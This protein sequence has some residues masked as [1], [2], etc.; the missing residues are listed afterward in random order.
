[1]YS[2]VVRQ[3]GKYNFNIIILINSNNFNFNVHFAVT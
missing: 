2:I 1:M 3:S